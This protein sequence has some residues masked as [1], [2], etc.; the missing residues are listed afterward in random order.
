L[1]FSTCVPV[2]APTKKAAPGRLLN[3]QVPGEPRFAPRSGVRIVVRAVTRVADA[4][5]A[6]CRR[7]R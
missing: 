7:P 3:R 6:G 5:A 4:I 2:S 1:T